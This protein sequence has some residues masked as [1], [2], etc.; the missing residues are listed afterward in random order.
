[1]LQRE[2]RKSIPGLILDEYFED[3]RISD[4][5]FRNW[6][7]KVSRE[8]TDDYPA[9]E[10]FSINRASR[11]SGG[12]DVFC[13]DQ[14]LFNIDVVKGGRGDGTARMARRAIALERAGSEYFSR[15]FIPLLDTDESLRAEYIRLKK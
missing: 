14:A 11:K 5:P 7:P 6:E 2:L 1:M 8:N 4:N 12:G 9:L 3:I 10:F 13:S 15:N